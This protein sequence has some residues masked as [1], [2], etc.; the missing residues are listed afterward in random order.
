MAIASEEELVQALT[1]EV[2]NRLAPAQDTSIPAAQPASAPG[3]KRALV[4]GDPKGLC[5]EGGWD[6]DIEEGYA[7]DGCIEKYAA[8][9]ITAVSNAQ[10][11]D[12]ALARDAQPFACAVIKALLT[13]IPVRMLESAPA[14]RRFAA[15]APPALAKTLRCYEEKLAAY[16]VEILSGAK[17]AAPA[18]ARE[19]GEKAT[20]DRRVITAELAKQLCADAEEVVLSTRDIITPLAR[21]VFGAARVKVRREG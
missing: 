19:C 7:K 18:K 10:L 14:W 11:C 6:I 4:L 15:G 1:R 3:G 21:D 13:G 8:V 17:A 20:K 16:G 5:L 2:M 12:I 9:Y